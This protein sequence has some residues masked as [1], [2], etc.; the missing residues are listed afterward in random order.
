MLGV[1]ESDEGEVL[2]V[3]TT[4]LNSFGFH[5][6]AAREPGIAAT[7]FDCKT[8]MPI[9]CAES[10]RGSRSM[11]TADFDAPPTVTCAT[12]LTVEMRCASVDWA[13]SSTADIGS[14]LERSTSCSTA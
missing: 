14:V 5:A 1:I 11:R 13:Y 2:L 3:P 8:P 4:W 12:P 6:L 10:L 7:A 9:P